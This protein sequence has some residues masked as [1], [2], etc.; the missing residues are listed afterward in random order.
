MRFRTF[1]I[2]LVCALLGQPATTNA[3]NG[4]DLPTSENWLVSVLPQDD[5]GSN[6]LGLFANKYEYSAGGCDLT[7]LHGTWT[8]SWSDP[9]SVPS[10][11]SLPMVE[12][13]FEARAGLKFGERDMTHDE[14]Y[15]MKTDFPNESGRF[16]GKVDDIDFGEVRLNSF[17]I[18]SGWTS[19][20]TIM[21]SVITHDGNR[22][23]FAFDDPDL[24]SRVSTAIEHISELCGATNDPF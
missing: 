13:V 5:S 7:I 4:P 21:Q 9:Q 1:V 24:A 2:A 15:K 11:L 18:E 10:P 14:R 8:Q 22:A 12:V 23:N 3:D 19:D 17:N 6:L 16:T 20:V